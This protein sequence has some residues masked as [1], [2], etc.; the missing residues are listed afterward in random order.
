LAHAATLLRPGGRIVFATCSLQPEE[1]E[2][3]LPRAASLGLV[4]DP[5]RAE[6]LPGLETALTAAS[7]LRTRP[8]MWAERGGLDG[9]FA[10][11]FVKR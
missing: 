8:D 6:E 5:I 7:T 9:F 11:R 3:H 2:A 1:G 10:A 4:P